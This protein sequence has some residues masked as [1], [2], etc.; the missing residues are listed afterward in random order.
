MATVRL[1]AGVLGL[2]GVSVVLVSYARSKSASAPPRPTVFERAPDASPD[3]SSSPE[4]T[5][6]FRAPSGEAPALSCEDARAVVQQ[7]RGHLGYE[8]P[9]VDPLALAAATSDWMDPYGLWSACPDSPVPT[10]LDTDS[11]TLI[12]ELEAPAPNCTAARA[13]GEALAKWTGELEL[14]FQAS[15][16]RARGQRT[17]AGSAGEGPAADPVLEVDATS[18]PGRTLAD[19]LGARIGAVER[20]LGA[21]A[22]PYGDLAAQR[23][24]PALDAEG[25]SRVVLAAAVRA[26][27]PLT[28]P[29][30]AW[31]PLDEEASVYDVELEAHPP[32]R[33]WDRASRT[34]F[35]VLVE[36][37]PLDP[38]RVGDV[39]VAVGGVATAGLPAEQLD[40]L[41]YSVTDTPTS[42][43]LVVLRRGESVLRTIE[44]PAP[45]ESEPASEAAADLP[46]YRVRYGAADAVVVEIHDVRSDLADE[47]VATVAK[48]LAKEPRPVIGLL[49]DLR[50]DG[51]GSTEGAIAAL[52]LFLPDA[53]LFPMARRDGSIEVDRAPAPPARDRW[54]HAVATLVDADTASAAEMIAGALAAYHRGP[55]VGTPTYGKGCAQEYLDD[56]TATGIL[57]LTTLL[58]A[59]PDGS[60]VQGVGLQPT[61]LLPRDRPA[62]VTGHE[63]EADVMHA[64]PTWRGPDVRDPTLIVQGAAGDGMGWPDAAGLVGPCPDSEVCQALRA[65]QGPSKRAVAVKRR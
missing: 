51:G 22:I 54:T 19:I 44:L 59:L 3:K 16:L 42:A 12:R 4:P 62:T 40:Q 1:L 33:L 60:P 25:W 28:D 14:R 50:G 34:A 63:R 36:S 38:L 45:P 52:G 24:F 43:P 23:F 47:L 10:V 18:R 17:D 9:R 49:L 6:A 2:V 65:L 39:V 5:F 37:D 8:P 7:V 31:A 53:P 57:R 27:V 61:F 21:E 64:P 48:E 11:E 29:H 35:G 26:Y 32:D 58:Y 46:V 41:A 15:R 20:A 55:I 30:G 13:A 56:E